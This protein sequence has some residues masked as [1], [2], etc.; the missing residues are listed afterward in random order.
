MQI[1]KLTTSLH[2]DYIQQTGVHLSYL[3][4]PLNKLS[5]FMKITR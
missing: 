4:L 1:Y 2:I 5:E 3:Q